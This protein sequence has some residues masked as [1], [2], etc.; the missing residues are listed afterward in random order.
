MMLLV[1]ALLPLDVIESGENLLS[2]LAQRVR[3]LTISMITYDIE[4][5]QVA[6]RWLRIMVV[7]DAVVVLCAG[8]L[9]GSWT[10]FTW[11]CL[12]ILYR[13]GS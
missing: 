12:V 4:D 9:T 8:V 3:T 13:K 11:H 1:M 6:G 7:V 2:L 5:I 10:R